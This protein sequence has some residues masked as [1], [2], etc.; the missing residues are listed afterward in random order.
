MVAYTPSTPALEAWKQSVQWQCKVN[1]PG[2]IEGP[3]AVTLVVLHP[4]LKRHEKEL[5]KGI[6]N[7]GRIWKTSKPDKD[8]L[9]KLV[10]DQMTKLD[11]FPDDSYVVGGDTQKAYAAVGEEEG[12]EVA[13]GWGDDESIL[14]V[15]SYGA[16]SW[17]RR[18]REFQRAG[19][20]AEEG[21]G[22]G[23]GSERSEPESPSQAGSSGGQG[24]GQ[25]APRGHHGSLGKPG[26]QTEE[27]VWEREC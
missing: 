19:K 26:G 27:T 1:H 11:Y 22:A 23:G 10:L 9:E 25:E 17:R 4:R 24:A 6:I 14:R 7:V 18:S 12:V 13:I 15:C 2:H 16:E 8:N 20:G 3:C 5:K 21:A